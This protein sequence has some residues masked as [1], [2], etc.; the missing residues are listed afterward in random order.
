MEEPMEARADAPGKKIGV[1]ISGG[2]AKI[3]FAAGVLEVMVEE[4]KINID[5]AYGISAGSLCT[6]ALCY[7]T[8]EFLEEMLLR[9]RNRN[10]VLRT[11]WRRMLWTLITG[12][13][14]ADGVFEM[15]TM[16]RLLETV[17]LNKTKIKGVVGYVK[18]QSGQIEY[19]S[20]DQVNREDFLDAVQ[21]SC[22][23]PAFCQSQR[24]GMDNFVDGGVI[25]VLPLKRIVEDPLEVTEVHVICLS[26]LPTPPIEKTLK[27]IMQVGERSID[28][29]I[30][31]A[32]QNDLDYAK[33]I[34]SLLED[35]RRLA[36]SGLQT[37]LEGGSLQ[38]WLADKRKIDFFIYEPEDAICDTLDYQPKTIQAGIKYGHEVA[39]KILA[40]YPHH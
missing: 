18:L 31:T 12:L 5:L 40:R 3:G 14:K 30:D 2:G 22:S 10:D 37:L 24:V 9:I 33:R 32:L 26:P 15:N 27:N 21:A 34:N 1:C 38:K 16:R 25:N 13:G 7:D 39:R 35:H 28:L 36:G 8:V 6:A 29:M 19:I 23:I 17:S 4:K 20:S 11:Q